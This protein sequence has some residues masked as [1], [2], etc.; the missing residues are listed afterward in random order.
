LSWRCGDDLVDVRICRK[1]SIGAGDLIQR[2]HFVKCCYVLSPQVWWRA[3][4][5]QYGDRSEVPG[6]E[7]NFRS[8][9]R[10]NVGPSQHYRAD[11]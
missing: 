5:D 10:G 4:V 2:R 7:K 11:A 1:A 6:N 3:G 8:S 9:E